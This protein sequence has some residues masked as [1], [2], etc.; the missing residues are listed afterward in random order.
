MDYLSQI[1]INAAKELLFEENIP[2]A[3][4]A[5]LCGFVNASHFTRYFKE[6]TGYTPAAFRR[7]YRQA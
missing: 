7:L 3:E 2:V 1:R 5:E 6:K 4:V